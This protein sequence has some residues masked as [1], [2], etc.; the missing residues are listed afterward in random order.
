[1]P[2]RLALTSNAIHPN[3]CLKTLNIVR[4]DYWRDSVPPCC[5]QMH[6]KGTAMSSANTG[7]CAS[8]NTELDS[9]WLPLPS[10]GSERTSNGE[11][12][13]DQTSNS[14]ILDAPKQPGKAL[15]ESAILLWN[16]SGNTIILL[17]ATLPR[18]GG[19][20]LTEP[21]W[22]S[23]RNRPHR[24][25]LHQLCQVSSGVKNLQSSE[26]R[27]RLGMDHCESDFPQLP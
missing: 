11:I 6:P 21:F 12:R 16:S 19:M 1:M 15:S 5:P 26:C 10:Y 14:R 22:K 27:W 3:P 13:H 7:I 23:G 17:E 2:N 20:S 25:K 8:S 18:S 9:N 4:I 24:P